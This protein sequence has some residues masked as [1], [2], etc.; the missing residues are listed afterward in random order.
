MDEIIKK[1]AK[2]M[3]SWGEKLHSGWKNE[4]ENYDMDEKLKSWTCAKN[5]TMKK[6]SD[7][8]T[9]GGHLV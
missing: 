6:S 4:N 9:W 5:E 1:V 8:F 7:W 3:E 2:W